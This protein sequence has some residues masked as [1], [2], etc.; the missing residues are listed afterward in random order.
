MSKTLNRVQ[1]HMEE[2]KQ[3]FPMK[4]IVGIFLQGSQNY[5]LETSNSDV[6]TKLIVTP[7]FRQIAFNKQPV[8]STHVRANN[9]HIDFKDLRLYMDMF[10]KQNINFVEILFTKYR[11]LNDAYADEFMRLIDAR[12]AV[13]HYNMWRAVKAMKGMAHEKHHAMEHR[14]PAKQDIVQKYG[15][16]GKQLS[17]LIR[18]KDFLSRYISGESYGSCLKANDRGY[19]IALK[20]QGY[21]SLETA[22]EVANE[23]IEVVDYIADDFCSSHPDEFDADTEALLQDV[24]YN[25]M[26]R[27]VKAE[28]M[29][30]KEDQDEEN[31]NALKI[32]KRYD[33]IYAQIRALEQEAEKTKQE[34]IGA[35]LSESH[36]A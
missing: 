16:D 5:G 27:S 29:P 8:S 12:E 31:S 19:L 26:E 25:I 18:I 17:H 14:Y 36:N 11:I 23:T 32:A 21:Y 9:E 7:A 13:A 10:R 24:Q 20:N 3:Y 4:N 35:L 34:L 22:R 28:L 1:E 33:G 15:Y 6:D 2:A 30:G